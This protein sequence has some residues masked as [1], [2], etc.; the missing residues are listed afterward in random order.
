MNK[1][2]V[3]ITMY[4]G[5]AVLFLSSCAITDILRLAPT[6]SREQWIS[7]W[8]EN[9]ACEPPCW[10]GITPGKDTLTEVTDKLKNN[11]GIDIYG[12]KYDEGDRFRN[13]IIYEY[14]NNHDGARVETDRNGSI[15]NEITVGIDDQENVKLQ[16][17]IKKYGSPDY[18]LIMRGHGGTCEISLVYK[19]GFSLIVMVPYFWEHCKVS[20]T[21]RVNSIKFFSLAIQDYANEY[22][23][24]GINTTAT[25]EDWKGYKWY[26][27]Q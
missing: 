22:G 23:H 20:P 14:Q 10:E 15:I 5:L 9:P 27:F 7:Q 1:R 24:N 2:F 19:Q 18:V 13:Y 6:Q 17:I 12:P 11:T 26:K 16:E 4:C 21:S 3:L 8:L 25:L